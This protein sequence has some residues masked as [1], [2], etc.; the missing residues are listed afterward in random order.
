VSSEKKENKIKM[1]LKKKDLDVE[2]S[3]ERKATR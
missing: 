1:K 3:V 2:E